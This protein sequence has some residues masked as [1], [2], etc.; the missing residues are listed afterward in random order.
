VDVLRSRLTALGNLIAVNNKGA[1][2]SPDFTQREIRAIE[3]V[4]S[5][6]VVRGTVAG[7]KTVGSLTVVTDRVGFVTVDASDSDVEVLEEALR[8]EFT[9]VTVNDGSKF[10]RSGMLANG[11]AAV[12][13][14]RTRGPE[15]MLISSALAR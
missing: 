3:D 2:V 7:M 15:L 1:V 12:V 14:N 11:R 10:I 4:L 13:G 5:V 8:V 6:E 9:R